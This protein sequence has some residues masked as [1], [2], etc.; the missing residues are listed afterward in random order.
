MRV[1]A[2]KVAV[3]HY[4]RLGIIIP[5]ITCLVFQHALP[6]SRLKTTVCAYNIQPHTYSQEGIKRWR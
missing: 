4:L 6:R 2:K 5:I 1:V 3:S